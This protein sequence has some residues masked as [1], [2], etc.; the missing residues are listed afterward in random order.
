MLSV[1]LL[2]LPARVDV[3]E[4][5]VGGAAR[6]SFAWG[7]QGG[8]PARADERVATGAHL[9]AGLVS[10]SSYQFRGSGSSCGFGSGSVSGSGG[11]SGSGSSSGSG[12]GS[13]SGSGSG[14]GGGSGSGSGSGSGYGSGSGKA[15]ALTGAPALARYLTRAVLE[16]LSHTWIAK[17]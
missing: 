7:T 5:A 12:G 15:P 16:T 14:S 3:R 4:A 11:G 8:H 10:A 17:L 1:A 13:G 9:G 2:G 6:S